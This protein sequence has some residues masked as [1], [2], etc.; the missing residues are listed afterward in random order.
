MDL[1]V[2]QFNVLLVILVILFFAVSVGAE[3]VRT[4]RITGKMMVSGKGPMADG[5][6]LFFSDAI[7]PPPLENR[8]MRTAD[9][10]SG[11]DDK[12]VFSAVLPE[13]EYYIGGMKR[14]TGKW[15]G[16]PRQGDIFFISKDE[17]GMPNTYIVS[18]GQDTNTGAFSGA[19]PYEERNYGKD[20][21]SDDGIPDMSDESSLD[22]GITA[23]EGS[24]HDKDGKP[25][26]D[27][28]VFAY[29][30]PMYEGLAFVSAYTGTDGRYLLRVHEGS[31]Y[32]LMIS[33]GFGS[34]FP[35][36]GM[37]IVDNG[38]KAVDGLNLMTG[39]VRKKV[40]IIIT[41]PNVE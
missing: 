37:A 33:G 6:A 30:N 24:I 19:V 11:T 14:V 28:V 8:Y 26:V 23:V 35:E 20:I 27:A 40:N 21:L 31:K 12:G 2:K 29:L 38:K 34:L 32:Y 1:K 4:G 7:G 9:H 16:P 10:V 39:E 15:S 36:A 22:Q 41:V 18:A 5:T 13:G 25:L 17:S 3:K